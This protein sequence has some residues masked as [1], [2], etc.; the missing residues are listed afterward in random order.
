MSA[1]PSSSSLELSNADLFGPLQALVVDDLPLVRRLLREML[2]HLGV[3]APIFEAP[4]GLEAWTIIQQSSPDLIICDVNMSRMDGMQLL[5]TLRAS[6]RHRHIPFLLITGEIS[7]DLVSAALSSD[8]DGYLMK[9]FRLSTLENRLRTI[10][11]PMHLRRFHAQAPRQPSST[12]DHQPAPFIPE[13][14]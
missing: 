5:Q 6:P 3:T 11:L 4:D 8:L 7:E 14:D 13:Q 2:R 9:P 10:L 12:P 1:D